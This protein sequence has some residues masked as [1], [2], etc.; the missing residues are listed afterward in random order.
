LQSAP[1]RVDARDAQWKAR[2][3]AS[4]RAASPSA[5][6][7]SSSVARSASRSARR[8][9]RA[10]AAAISPSTR[11]RAASSS[12]GPDSVVGA[13]R[14]RRRR[15][16]HEDAVADPH[17]DLAGDLE[18]DDRLAHR[19]PRHAELARELALA[20]SR[21]PGRN[22][23]RSISAAIWSRCGGRA[24]AAPQGQ[25]QAGSLGSGAGRTSFDG[26]P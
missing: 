14:R 17:L 23:P 6:R 10:A 16:A 13:P 4:R 2:S 8:I 25:R 12:N 5:A 24:A 1:L 9:V 3:A 22:S 18:R 11:P 7:I 19:G 20:G 26:S 15:R 21:A